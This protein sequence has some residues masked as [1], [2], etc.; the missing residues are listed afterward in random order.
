MNRTQE[1]RHECLLQLYGSG[2]IPIS[3]NHLR[4]VAKRQGFDYSESEVRDQLHFLRGQNLCEEITDRITGEN[5][6]IITSEGMLAY[7]QND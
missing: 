5:K 2:S 1:I 6:Y 7:E 3:I 4:K